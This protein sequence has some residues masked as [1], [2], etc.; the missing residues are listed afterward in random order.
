MKETLD[1]NEDFTAALAVVVK[2]GVEE[3]VPGPILFHRLAAMTGMV[4]LRQGSY[5]SVKDAFCEVLIQLK[6]DIEEHE[7]NASE[8]NLDPKSSPVDNNENA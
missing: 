4:G 8:T 2:V 6:L 7:K 5:S 3:G 1:P